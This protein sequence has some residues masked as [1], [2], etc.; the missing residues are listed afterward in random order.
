MAGEGRRFSVSM[1]V[2]A[3]IRGLWQKEHRWGRCCKPDPL[4]ERPPCR[5]SR[6]L[7]LQAGN[8]CLDNS[9]AELMEDVFGTPKFWAVCTCV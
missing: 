7:S 3:E 9:G 1:D 8:Q 5:A 4:S 6:R 2:T